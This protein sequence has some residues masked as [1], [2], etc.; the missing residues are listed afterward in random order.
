MKI[1]NLKT[2][3]SGNWITASETKPEILED[4][5][6]GIENSTW[7]TNK[8]RA[9]ISTSVE[10]NTGNLTSVHVAYRYG[11]KYQGGGQYWQHFLG[12]ERVHWKKLDDGERM[13]ILDAYENMPAW[14]KAP[15]K[16]TRDYLKP[17]ET[18]RLEVDEQGTI[19][20][21]KYLV[22]TRDGYASPQHIKAV[23][24]NN[25]LTADREP[26]SDNLHGIYAMKHPRSKILQAYKKPGRVLVRLALSGTVVEAN[27]GLRAH[28]AL[29]VGVMS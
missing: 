10:V 23:W 1:V 17:G 6:L 4:G 5:S 20:G 3:H 8:G 16:L 18:R 11:G 26:T 9:E 21:Y 19:Y 12:G 29:I 27:E 24:I 14:V 28:H 22:V 7:S 13:L 25:Q 15:G 2:R